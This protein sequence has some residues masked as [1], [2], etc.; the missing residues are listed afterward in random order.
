MTL[1]HTSERLKYSM[2]TADDSELMIELD[3]DPEVMRYISHGKI[4]NREDIIKTY[5]PRMQSYSD[6]QV[7]WG[8]WKTFTQ[9]TDEFVGWF[10]LR[11][12]KEKPSEVEIGWRLKQKFWGKGYGTEG[13]TIFCNHALN[14]NGINKVYAIA[15]PENKGSRR[16]MEKIGLKYVKTYFHQDPLFEEEAVLYEMSK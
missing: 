12:N 3:S 8:I 2:M 9:D 11:P 16:I 14:Q 13:A 1:S 7:G 15:M 5:V 6:Y 10:L 4:N